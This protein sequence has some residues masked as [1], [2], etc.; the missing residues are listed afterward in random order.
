MVELALG[1]TSIMV[2]LILSMPCARN[3][4]EILS[5]NPDQTIFFNTVPSEDEDQ[6]A[7]LF[8]MDELPY[9]WPRAHV[10]SY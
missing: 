3:K 5:L 8:R 9:R 2:E 7:A 10:W 1:D 6:P 4:Y